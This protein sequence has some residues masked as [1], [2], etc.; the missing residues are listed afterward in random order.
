MRLEMAT[1]GKSEKNFCENKDN[2]W[3]NAVLIL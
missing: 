1:G 2:S 3:K